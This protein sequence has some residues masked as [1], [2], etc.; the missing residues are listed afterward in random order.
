MRREEP[1][2]ESV[3]D[4]E[5]LRYPS[6]PLANVQTLRIGKTNPDPCPSKEEIEYI[7]LD[8]P[9]EAG[10]LAACANRSK[11]T[12]RPSKKPAKQLLRRRIE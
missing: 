2:R 4:V 6:L 5:K 8:E 1:G 10:V 11:P 9:I 7:S 12:E 3:A